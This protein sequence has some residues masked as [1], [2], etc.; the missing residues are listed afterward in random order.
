VCARVLFLN[1]YA[2]RQ[3]HAVLE[4]LCRLRPMHTRGRV[5]CHALLSVCHPC[6]NST[7][8]VCQLRLMLSTCV[9]HYQKACQLMLSVCTH[10]CV[11]SLWAHVVPEVC[12]NIRCDAQFACHSSAFLYN[13]CSKSVGQSPAWVSS[14]TLLICSNLC[15]YVA[16]VLPCSTG[17]DFRSGV[18]LPHMD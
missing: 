4:C 11:P 15:V 12:Q 17:T 3:V 7:E 13:L 8:W 6:K 18:H 9:L 1:E 5:F 10:V 2:A 14:L 16:I